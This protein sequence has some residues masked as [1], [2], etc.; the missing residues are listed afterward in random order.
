MKLFVTALA[1]ASA[2]VLAACGSS[3]DEPPVRTSLFAAANSPYI[4][5]ARKLPPAGKDWEAVM[6]APANGSTFN[7]Y[8][9]RDYKSLMLFE[10]DRMSDYI[11]ADM[12]ARRALLTA[13]GKT[14]EPLVL[15]DFN[16][17]KEHVPALS[18]A[19]ANLLEMFG[20]GSREKFPE[21]S[22]FAQSR[23]DCWV[24]QQ[25]ENHQPN[26][27]ARCRDEFIAALN[28]LRRK[29]AP[30][31]PPPPAPAPAAAPAPQFLDSYTVFFE[32]DS[33]ELTAEDRDLLNTVV[34]A[35]QTQN[36]GAS[37]I[38]YTDT[39]GSAEYN[40]ALSERRAKAVSDMLLQAGIRPAVLTTT[41]RG[42]NDLAVQTPD[43]TPDQANR[44][45]VINIR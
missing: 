26:H 9:S 29:M 7:A 16:L 24:E 28:D 33:A 35:L 8:L 39:A 37:I 2:F 44:R 17:P 4:G 23:F 10:V 40:Q 21:E 22:A 30:P 38:G 1:V 42:E 18:E 34:R 14:V 3:G 31:P 13:Q 12:Y 11:S 41:G 15:A 25:E 5:Q 36:A 6:K 20:K 19:R 27:I 45:A 43:N 32:F